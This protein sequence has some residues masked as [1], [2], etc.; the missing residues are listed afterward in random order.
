MRAGSILRVHGTAPFTLHWSNDN[1]KTGRYS[2]SQPKYM[3]IDYVDLLTVVTSPGTCI[4]FS[5]LATANIFKPTI[6]RK[7]A[8]GNAQNDESN[9]A[10]P[11]HVG[12][13]HT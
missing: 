2:R 9:H 12:V 5:L 8:A 1:W 7:C 11:E 10:P 4:E 13:G 6:D 3:Q